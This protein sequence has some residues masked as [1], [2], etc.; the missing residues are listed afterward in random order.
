[1]PKFTFTGDPGALRAKAA[2]FAE[3]G[4]TELVYQPV[5]DIRRELEAV[6]AALAD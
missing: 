4:V 2:A 3:K 1:V 6:A 5:G